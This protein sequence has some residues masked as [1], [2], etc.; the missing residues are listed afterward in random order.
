VAATAERFGR[1]DGL[2]NNAGVAHQ[3]RIDNPDEAKLDEMWEVNVKAPLRLIRAAF[4]YL[5]QAGSGRVVNV[6]SLSGKR[7]KSADIGG[8]AM[9]K[10][11]AAALTHA[12][13]YAGWDDGIRATSICPGLVD[14]DMTADVTAVARDRM[15][16]PATV[17]HL[18]ATALALPNTASVA[19]IPVNC[20]LESL[21]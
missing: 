4:P 21:F 5:K 16:Q 13:R 3:F 12:V 19:E 11:A 8:Y 17:A 15:I 20:V 1:I 7:V 14:T 10:H 2:V 9:T 18:V 6:V